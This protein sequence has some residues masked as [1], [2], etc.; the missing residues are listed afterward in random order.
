MINDE[1]RG[2][3]WERIVLMCE[4]PFLALSATIDNAGMLRDWLAAVA[5]RQHNTPISQ[6]SL[7][8]LGLIKTFIVNDNQSKDELLA[9][10]DETNLRKDV[11]E[12]IS[13]EQIEE[14]LV[15]CSSKFEV[16]KRFGSVN[17]KLHKI[18]SIVSSLD[19]QQELSSFVNK[20]NLEFNDVI[21][22]EHKQPHTDFVY[23]TFAY[24]GDR[25]YKFGEGLKEGFEFCDNKYD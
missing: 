4:C 22:I 7:S 8:N 18:R 23:Y 20:F 14:L 11:N 9:V 3:V 10:F 24:D 17:D 6:S 5:R 25:N 19:D 21:L 13:F 12:N 1:D 2:K 15:K 16:L